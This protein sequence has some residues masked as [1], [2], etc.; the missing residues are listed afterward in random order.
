M[1]CR[2]RFGVLLP[3]LLTLAACSARYR[4]E[5]ENLHLPS[6]W[7][8]ARGTASGVGAV[9]SG[10]FAGKLEVIWEARC[11]DKPAGPLSIYHSALVYPGTKKK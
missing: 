6:A 5:R 2:W 11:G 3:V 10:A 9:D 4:I 7:P 8:F 1:F